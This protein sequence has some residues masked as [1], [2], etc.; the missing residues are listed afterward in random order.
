VLIALYVPLFNKLLQTVP[1]GLHEWGIL[2]VYAALS[3]IVY[4]TGKR[5]TIARLPAEKVAQPAKT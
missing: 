4:E 2:L 1:I 3:I 5:F